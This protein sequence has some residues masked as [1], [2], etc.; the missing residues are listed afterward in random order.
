[1][2]GQGDQAQIHP[3]LLGPSARR[4][5]VVDGG[6][7]GTGRPGEPVRSQHK[8]FGDL[9][10]VWSVLERLDVAGVVDQVVPLVPPSHDP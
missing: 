2:L 5:G 1:M 7:L 4:G 9:A 6:A 3:L 8:K 10:A